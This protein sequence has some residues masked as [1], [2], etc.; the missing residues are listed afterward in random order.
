MVDSRE[1]DDDELIGRRTV[2]P[3]G[4]ERFTTMG[5]SVLAAVKRSGVMK[6]SGRIRS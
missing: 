6:L 5:E 3:G 2:M 4:R 1:A